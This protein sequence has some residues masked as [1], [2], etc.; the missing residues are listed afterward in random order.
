MKQFDAMKRPF[1]TKVVAVFFL[2]VLAVALTTAV[3]FYRFIDRSLVDDYAGS[4]S[5]FAAYKEEMAA[6]SFYI[7]AGF[8]VAALIAVVGYGVYFSHKVAGPLVRVRRFAK[9]MGEGKSGLKVAFRK[10][11]LIHPLAQS[12]ERCAGWYDAKRSEVLHEVEDL[13]AAARGL[14]KAL[15]GSD[16]EDVRR[17]TDEIARASKDLRQALSEVKL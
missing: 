15:E 10:G 3:L 6:K 11:D 12:A 14:E 17:K 4:L 5:L 7:Y 16:E 2:T 8:S 13:R 9:E 1:Y